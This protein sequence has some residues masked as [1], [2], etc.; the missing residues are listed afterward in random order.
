MFSV[1]I[2]VL[3]SYLGWCNMLHTKHAFAHNPYCPESWV[4]D[5]CLVILEKSWVVAIM[6]YE[7]KVLLR[8]IVYYSDKKLSAV[9]PYL[10][11]LYC[12]VYSITG[13]LVSFFFWQCY[14]I[15]FKMYL[16][17][18]WKKNA[19]HYCLGNVC[20]FNI[21]TFFLVIVLVFFQLWSTIS[22]SLEIKLPV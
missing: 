15:C 6:L 5:C 13:F 7:E 20:L 8:I 17:N 2:L 22:Q 19:V 1:F 21:I 10:I 18:C 3:N 11:S 14:I 4:S 16:N 12:W 9:K